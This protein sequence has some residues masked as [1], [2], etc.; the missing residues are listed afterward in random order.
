MSIIVLK[1]RDEA[2]GNRSNLLRRHIHQVNLSRRYNGEVS[3][4]ATFHHIADKCAVVVKRGIT[5]TDDMVFLLLSRQIYDV[6]IVKVNSAI[7][8]PAVRSLDKSEFI[9]FGIYTER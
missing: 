8:H 2:S 1:E 3:I 9:D 6:S 4:L 5:L 7:L